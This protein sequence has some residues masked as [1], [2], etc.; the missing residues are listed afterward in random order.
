MKRVLI[1]ILAAFAV[2][3]TTYG[4]GVLDALRFSEIKYEGTARSMAMGN[5]FT[6]LGAESYSISI[7]PASSAVYNFSEFT[8]TPSISSEQRSSIY[9]QNT[10]EENWTRFGIANAA[11]VSSF[12]TNNPYGL[13]N[14]N[15]GVAIN[16]LNNYSSRSYSLGTNAQ[17]SWLGSLASGLSGVYNGTLNINDEWNPFYDF[18]EA[19]WKEILAWNSNLIDP[20][21]DSDYDYIAATENIRD[22]QI[23]QAG[24]VEQEF[25]REQK[26]SL[27]EVL[28]NVGANYSD[29]FFMGINVGIQSI[30][31]SDYQRYSEYAV[32]PALFDAQFSSFSHIY[33]QN[34]TGT[35]VNLKAGIIAL[36]FE[37]LRIGASIA[38]PTWF[39]I[40]DTWEEEIDAAYSDGYTSNILSPLGEYRYRINTP[41]RWNIGASYVLGKLALLSI[42]Y[43][44]IDYSSIVMMS[45]NGDKSEFRNDNDYMEREF[46]SAYSLRAGIEIKPAKNT[47]LR[48][49]YTLYSQPEKN[50]GDDTEY[51]SGG[52]GFSGKAGMF[53]D[54]AFRKRLSS[55]ENFSLYGDYAGI[56]APVGTMEKNKWNLLLTLGF[57]F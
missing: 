14:I 3:S 36:P 7:N 26:G 32:S 6:S 9:L 41:L 21:P 50:F 4:Q 22:F 5:A 43:E 34:S 55:S 57:R 42:D 12:N 11:L 18:P 29:I 19:S 23:I 33:R 10:E 13:K 20:L 1:T 44:G 17:S 16:R 39:F 48:A 47:A 27:A 2:T 51:I 28:F 40:K 53:L 52:V 54:M 31:F 8:F 15:I 37:G 49:G 46:N 35:G 25:Y 45:D 30:E 56:E 24:A 38:T